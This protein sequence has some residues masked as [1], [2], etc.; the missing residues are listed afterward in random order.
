[1]ELLYAGIDTTITGE[2]YMKTGYLTKCI[3][4]S[5]QTKITKTYTWKQSSIT[6]GENEQLYDGKF[7]KYL[8]GIKFNYADL[9]SSST[10]TILHKYLCKERGTE[11]AIYNSIGCW[12]TVG[13]VWKTSGTFVRPSPK[14]KLRAIIRDRQAPVVIITRRSLKETDDLPEIRARGTLRRVLGEMQFR[15]FL[16]NGFITVRGKSGKVYQVFTG[17]GITAV[18]KDGKMIERLCVVLP[19]DFPPTDSVIMRFLLILN[20][21]NE[22]RKLSVVYGADKRSS[23]AST[24]PE[25]RS[26]PDVFR[27]LKA[28]AA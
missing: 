3:N 7:N 16:R 28:R 23:Q 13:S 6:T 12:D 4:D 17:Q 15:S 1:M 27:E 18:Y 9:E 24:Q 26:L 10:D 22:F 2:K 14:E 11:T 20:D 8:S 25:I 5:S 19:Y 21:E